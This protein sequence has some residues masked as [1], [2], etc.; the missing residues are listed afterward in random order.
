MPENNLIKMEG[1]ITDGISDT[2][3]GYGTP[4]VREG[5]HLSRIDEEIQTNEEEIQTN[6]DLRRENN[7]LMLE[8]KKTKEKLNWTTRRY[9]KVKKECSKLNSEIAEYK[10]LETSR[11]QYAIECTLN[12]VQ[13]GVK[14]KED[15]LIP[16][17]NGISGK[18]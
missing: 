14:E 11:I 16:I 13:E 18:N 15:E 7:A 10:K 5:G 4:L 6:E 1:Q 2:D 9:E 17:L 8:N 3:S 12:K